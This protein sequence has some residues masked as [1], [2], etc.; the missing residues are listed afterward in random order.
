MTE[1]SARGRLP[2]RTLVVAGVALVAAIAGYLWLHAPRNSVATDDAYVRADEVVVSPKVRGMIQAVLVGADQKVQAGEAL[3]RIDPEEYQAGLAGA[4][5]DLMAAQAAQQAAVA[6]LGRLDAEEA[7]ARSQVASAE[8]AAGGAGA[9]DPALRSAFETARGQ[10]LVAARSRGEIEAGLAQAKA[11]MFRARTALDFAGRNL[12]DTTVRAP[13]DGLVGDLTAEIGAFVQP[14][15]SL[16]VLVQPRTAYV[17]A[18]FKETQIGAIHPGQLARVRIDA[19]EG[20]VFTGRVV[21]LAPGSGT[22]FSLTPFEPGSG[23]FTKIVQRLGVRIALDPGQSGLA[24]LR[25]GLSASVTVET[26]RAR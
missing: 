17:L 13:A 7:L 5:G 10:A 9:R 16:M 6:G 25:P 4:R 15:M 3:A 11:S 21:G 12:A 8:K 26:G 22:E 20:H 24:A 2:T 19:L 14:G 1:I 18:N 23:N